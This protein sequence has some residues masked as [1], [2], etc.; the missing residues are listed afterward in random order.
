MRGRRRR[1]RTPGLG[2][3]FLARLARFGGRGR[4]ARA[5]SVVVVVPAVLVLVDGP[6]IG[7]LRFRTGGFLGV[8]LGVLAAAAA[9]PATSASAALRGRVLAGR[10]VLSGLFPGL[11]VRR[12]FRSIVDGRNGARN[13]FELGVVIGVFADF[14]QRGSRR[15]DGT[16]D[17]RFA[18]VLATLAAP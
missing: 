15:G 10:V 13:D 2:S 9:A 16:R 4:S 3:F 11:I 17:A 14:L 8:A 12:L 6:L 7:G 18:G 1:V 5:A